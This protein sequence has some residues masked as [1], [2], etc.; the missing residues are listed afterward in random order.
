M[1]VTARLIIIVL[2]AA[3]IATAVLGLSIYRIHIS[4]L[5]TLEELDSFNPGTLLDRY[6]YISYSI[7]VTSPAG[8]ETYEAK[9][10]ND[11]VAREGRVELYKEGKL[12]Y[13]IEYEYSNG[14]D[15]LRRVEPNGTATSLN[16]NE[17]LQWFYTSARLIVVGGDIADIEPF[18]GAGPI[19]APYF[20]TEELR[21]DWDQVLSQRQT[22][23]TL[24]NI[25]QLVPVSSRI[26]DNEYRGV[27][28]Q[29]AGI[30]PAF[31]PTPWALPTLTMTFV[32]I[33]DSVLASSFI[34]N[35][36]TQEGPVILN[37]ELNEVRF[38]G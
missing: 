2:F 11:P 19:L 23:V 25:A 34:I 6:T 20:L 31:A 35:Y 1:A 27:L 4:P 13:T 33:E 9:L 21:I 16:L 30:S 17:S 3:T 32:K 38:S 10:Y 28:V 26:G 37:L 18:P 22:G 12:L 5:R 36:V 29:I 14:L 7:N 15:S 24:V 8:N